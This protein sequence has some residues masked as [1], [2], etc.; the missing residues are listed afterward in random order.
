MRPDEADFARFEMYG[1][2]TGSDAAHCEASAWAGRKA[3]AL[4]PSGPIELEAFRR[5]LQSERVQ[6][7]RSLVEC[8]GP[9]PA[10]DERAIAVPRLQGLQVEVQL[11]HALRSRP[12][13]RGRIVA[14]KL[15]AARA[16]G[17]R[18]CS[19]RPAERGAAARLPR[20]RASPVRAGAKHAS[21]APRRR[22]AQPRSG[23]GV[24][25]L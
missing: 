1:Y 22:I 20:P 7:L 14:R 13:G 5:V 19:L 10:R 24:G 4:G 12:F 25:K 18:K 8:I 15:W 23:R 9:I 11:G 21:T 17:Q 6:H 2:C 16:A 3:A